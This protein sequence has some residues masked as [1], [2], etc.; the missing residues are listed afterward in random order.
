MQDLET[1]DT[2]GLELLKG[3]D[4]GTT[5]YG[6]IR[7]VSASGMT[8][9]ISLKVIRGAND[10][11]GDTLLDVTYTAAGVLGDKVK[12]YHGYNVINVSGAGMDMVFHTV[13]NL[14]L[15]LHGD[16]YFFRSEL[17]ESAPSVPPTGG[18]RG[19]S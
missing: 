2:Y 9:N 8:R 15:A 4:R 11:H 6:L 1:K 13:Y 10:L 17:L 3:L 12:N 16:G 19:V 7:S 14:G 18:T 5:I